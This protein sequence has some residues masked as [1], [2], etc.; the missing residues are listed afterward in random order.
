MGKCSWTGGTS[1]TTQTDRGQTGCLIKKND[2]SVSK[3]DRIDLVLLF[4]NISTHLQKCVFVWASPPRLSFI[5]GVIVLYCYCQ[6]VSSPLELARCDC[7]SLYS[8]RMYAQQ[9][10]FVRC[11]LFGQAPCMPS[12]VPSRNITWKISHLPRKRS[13]VWRKRNWSDRV[14]LVL[15]GASGLY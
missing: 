7:V 5:F 8:V 12:T 1:G 4:Y 10:V 14:C 11:V 6:C 2:Q 3:N 15:C 13:K 9:R